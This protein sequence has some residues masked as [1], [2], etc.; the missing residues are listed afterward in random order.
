MEYID[1]RVFDF[2]YEMAMRDATMRTAF[3]FPGNKKNIRQNLQAKNAVNKYIDN[4]LTGNAYNFYETE[5]E[6]ENAL[7]QYGF[8]FGNCQKLINMTAKYFYIAS[9]GNESIKK[10]FEKCHCPMDSIMIQNAICCYSQKSNNAFCA[11]SE[12]IKKIL[13]NTSWSRLMR[14]SQGN[15]PYQYEL[16]QDVIAYLAKEEGMTPLEYD[17]CKWNVDSSLFDEN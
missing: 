7:S 1:C 12:N 9:Y 11:E 5:S 17:Y 2:V 10:N 16:F 6:V 4:I 8:S 14:D 3:R 15:A 13:K